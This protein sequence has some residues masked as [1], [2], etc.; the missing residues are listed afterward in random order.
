M[1]KNDYW[2]YTAQI[3]ETYVNF[4]ENLVL[5]SFTSISYFL[6]RGPPAGEISLIGDRSRE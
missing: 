3:S 2:D 5:F 1:F 6:P 4:N